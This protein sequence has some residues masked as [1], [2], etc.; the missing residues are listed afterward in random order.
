MEAE[1]VKV[2]LLNE[3]VHDAHWVVLGDEVVQ[4]L[5]QQRDLAPLL[6]LDESLHEQPPHR[7][8]SIYAINAFS[9]NLGHEP[10]LAAGSFWASHLTVLAVAG[11]KVPSHV[12]A[13]IR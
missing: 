9:H 7:V 11:A 12:E 3:G 10:S 2:E 6:T 4:T 1:V 5:G 13:T 8:A